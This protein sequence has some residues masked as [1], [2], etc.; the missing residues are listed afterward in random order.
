MNAP[1][2]R[3]GLALAI[4]LAFLSLPVAALPPSS[5]DAAVLARTG[6]PVTSIPTASDVNGFEPLDDE[7]VML[8]SGDKHY[9]L[10]LNREC[11]GLRWAKHVGVTASDDTIWA[12]FDALTAD[13]QSCPIRAIHLVRDPEAGTL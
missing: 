3:N 6:E 7:H 11:Y 12:G 5:P 9:L 10:T 13:G 1:A 8:T 2:G 4:L